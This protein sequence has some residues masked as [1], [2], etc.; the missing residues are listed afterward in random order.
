MKLG[1]FITGTDT[2]VGKTTV[3]CLLLNI[4]NQR[5]YRTAAV[6]PIASGCEMTAQG[7]KSPDA[8]KLQTAAHL[9][10]SYDNINPFA[11]LPPIAPHIAAKQVNQK[12]KAANVYSKCLPILQSTADCILIEGVGG[13]KVPLNEQE[14]MAD[15]A[16][17]F[18]FPVIM[19]VQLK[20]GCLNAALLTYESIQSMSVPIAGWIANAPGEVMLCETENINTLLKM[21]PIPYLGKYPDIHIE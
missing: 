21:L 8:L 4:F 6:K 17:L 16:V 10:F 12:L 13:W 7:L 9:Q 11:F 3:A 14:T 1:F 19:V 18:G 5:G 20:L 2:G 15:L